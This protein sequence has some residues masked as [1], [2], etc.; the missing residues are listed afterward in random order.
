MLGFMFIQSII[1][2]LLPKSDKSPLL[3][4]Y[5]LS[6]L[7]L[8]TFNLIVSAMLMLVF[9]LGKSNSSIVRRIERRLSR[10]STTLLRI[11]SF[12]LFL[13]KPESRR[14]NVRSSR[15]QRESDEINI[16]LEE[17]QTQII[18]S[19]STECN[20]HP[21][22]IDVNDIQ[23]YYAT[24]RRPLLVGPASA[25]V[26]PIKVSTYENRGS[27]AGQF[28]VTNGLLPNRAAKR[29]IT[30]NGDDSRLTPSMTPHSASNSNNECESRS[31]KRRNEEYENREAGS[32]ERSPEKVKREETCFEKKPKRHYN[33]EKFWHRM[34]G[35]LSR[36]ATSLLILA[37]LLI[38]I[39]FL[40]PIF[41]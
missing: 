35:F 1:A 31:G 19:Q 8:S 17:R 22:Q 38:V 18:S 14:S 23:S 13:C 30:E 15:R 21:L 9:N 27:P 11:Y 5:L 40:I 12:G 6:A 25:H 37:Q 36:I 2:T 29:N 16:S 39:F 4:D 3:A 41:V 34:A 28:H 7:I 20:P 10:H 24:T 32:E 33:R 26:S